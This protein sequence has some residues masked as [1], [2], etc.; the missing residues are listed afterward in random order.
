M[1]GAAGRSMIP[2]ATRCLMKLTT[3]ARVMRALRRSYGQTA[4]G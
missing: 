2:R 4:Y 3:S 1:R